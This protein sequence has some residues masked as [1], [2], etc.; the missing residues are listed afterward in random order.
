[1][2]EPRHTDAGL[3]QIGQVDHSPAGMA[4][5]ERAA[6]PSPAEEGAELAD[7]GSSG[8]ETALRLMKLSPMSAAMAQQAVERTD[9]QID[10]AGLDLKSGEI[11]LYDSI[12]GAVGRIEQLEVNT[13]RV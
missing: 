8:R 12:T 7:A 4:A 13:G 2:A 10:I 6:R 9:F 5:S 11:H 3:P 1:Q